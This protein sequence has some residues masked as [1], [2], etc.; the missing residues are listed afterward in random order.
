MTV[1]RHEDQRN[2]G[3]IIDNLEDTSASK[4]SE[5]ATA[6]RSFKLSVGGT[7]E[8]SANWT[9]R[10]QVNQVNW[11]LRHGHPSCRSVRLGELQSRGSRPSSSFSITIQHH[12]PR[13]TPSSSSTIS[14]T[15]SNI[16]VLVH[17][18]YSPLPPQLTPPLSFNTASTTAL[19]HHHQ[20]P[21]R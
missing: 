10:L 4:P 2:W 14:P 19:V 17:H 13:T 12:R 7:G 15:S 5:L 3:I 21:R 16:T 20:R 6:T 18:R 1:M 11:Q 9:I 8:L